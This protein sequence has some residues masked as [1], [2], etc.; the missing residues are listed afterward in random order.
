MS[1]KKSRHQP[2]RIQVTP[3]LINNPNKGV[4][5]LEANDLFYKLEGTSILSV[6]WFFGAI[7]VAFGIWTANSDDIDWY[8]GIFSFLQIS[9]G[10]FFFIYGL[11]AKKEKKMFVLDRLRYGYLS[12]FILFTLSSAKPPDFAEHLKTIFKR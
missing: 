3:T 2:H 6:S 4:I 11:T 5:I 8:Y 1:K 10:L 9:I 12:R 7:A